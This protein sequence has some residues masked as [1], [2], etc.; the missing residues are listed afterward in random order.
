MKTMN[1]EDWDSE[2]V[3]SI[4]R[5]DDSN[6]SDVLQPHGRDSRVGRYKER[7][8]V[9]GIEEIDYRDAIMV[10]VDLPYWRAW[11][12]LHQPLRTGGESERHMQMKV[13]AAA[14][15]DS[16]GHVMPRRAI[17]TSTAPIPPPKSRLVLQDGRERH[18]TY[19]SGVFE[20]G[21]G[22]GISD[23]AC[24]CDDCT[25]AVEMGR[26]DPEK[27]LLAIDEPMVD[28]LILGENAGGGLDR[29]R[30]SLTVFDVSG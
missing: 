1:R 13:F 17:D 18:W 22:Y 10:E 27:Y 2:H 12:E 8:V 4:E 30:L 19:T 5:F 3:R 9:E 20:R 11:S 16:V 23:V 7:N 24:C 14:Y 15:L 25:V 26:M 29:R 28:Y 21:L 6:L